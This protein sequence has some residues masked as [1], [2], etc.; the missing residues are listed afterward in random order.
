MTETSPIFQPG[1]L[2]IAGGLLLVG[3][4]DHRCCWWTLFSPQTSSL[5]VHPCGFHNTTGVSPSMIKVTALTG[6][7]GEDHK[8]LGG[9]FLNPACEVKMLGWQRTHPSSP[10]PNLLYG[11]CSCD[12]SWCHRQS[13][14]TPFEE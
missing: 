8:C 4:L 13:H 1:V 11:K 5:G 12:I 9:V 3:Y 6:G 2:V 10:S 14:S 7:K